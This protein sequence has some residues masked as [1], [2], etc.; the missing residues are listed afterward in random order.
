MGDILKL[1][2]CIGNANI[3][4][5]GE[6][7]LV[8]TI[9]S[10]LRDHGLG[11]LSYTDT[12]SDVQPTDTVVQP[13]I[14]ISK[15]K[16]SDAEPIASITLPNIKDIVMKD[17]P[18]TE[19][20]WLLIY[21]LY[22]SKDGT[23]TFTMDDLRQKYRDSN[24]FTDARSK[25][26]STNFKK[27]VSEDWFIGINDTDYS[28]SE[29][30][31]TAAR[32]ILNRSQ[33]ATKQKTKKASQTHAKA[34]YHLIDLGLDQTARDALKSY[35][36]SFEKLN[37]IEKALVISVWLTEH[38]SVSEVN[39]HTIF[40]VLRSIGQNTSYDIKSSL[41]NGKNKNNYFIAGDSQGFYK[42]HHIGEDHVRT[43]ESKRDERVNE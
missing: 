28:L 25:N 42:V 35:F 26:F 22:S 4:L 11:K 41:K 16:A 5:E 19:A 29:T 23:D 3:E 32:E 8:H 10:E 27:A 21:A 14:E 31:K 1:K 38:N 39:E 37:N 34:S 6:G 12:S 24:R 33:P 20:E 15:D 36:E 13:N 17:L 40:S 7:S 18:K 43:L 2:V 30:G 9:F